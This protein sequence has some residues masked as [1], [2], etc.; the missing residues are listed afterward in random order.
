MKKLLWP[1]DLAPENRELNIK[2][3]KSIKALTRE[4]AVEIEPIHVLSPATARL[5][6][7]IL[8]FHLD[9]YRKAIHGNIGRILTKTKL[10]KVTPCTIL[11][12]SDSSLTQ[13]AKAL[14]DYAVKNQFD[15]IAIPTRGKTGVSRVLMGSFVEALVHQAATPVF[16]IN[17]REVPATKYKE[18]LF[19]T[20]LSDHSVKAFEEI[21]PLAKFLSAKINLFHQVDYTSLI[22][23]GFYSA[24]VSYGPVIKKDHDQKMKIMQKMVDTGEAAGISVVPIVTERLGR[25][26]DLIVKESKK[27]KNVIIAM[28]SQSGPISAFWLG[29]ISREVLRSAPCP[30]WVIRK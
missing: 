10:I 24:G 28:D 8:K 4:H 17:P 23:L 2:I 13:A 30:V 11:E 27:M 19:P 22:N 3:A 12:T 29:S 5:N 16:V 7:E 21:L 15:I 26:A 1:I 14:A 25:V 6:F 18:I 9:D 20:D